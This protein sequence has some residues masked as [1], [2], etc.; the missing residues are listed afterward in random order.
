MFSSW[1]T[2]TSGVYTSTV[3]GYNFMYLRNKFHVPTSNVSFFVCFVDRA[4]LYN[5]INKTNLVHNFSFM[6][7]SILYMFS[8]TMCPS[9]GEVTVS[10]R[11]LVFVT[12]CGWPS[13][14]H[15]R[16]SSTQSNKYQVS[17]WYSYF[18][19]WWAHSCP[20]HVH[21]RNK[22]KRKIVHR[23]GFIYKITRLQCFINSLL[24]THVLPH[25]KHNSYP[26]DGST[27]YLV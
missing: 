5:L 6:F 24:K 3:F 17:R 11:H 23:V 19:W 8:G 1:P 7:I 14:M 25:R 26:L 22:L 12:P 9:S 15:T 18:S 2:H 27:D 4:P 13:G 21:N 20:K 16:R 10:T